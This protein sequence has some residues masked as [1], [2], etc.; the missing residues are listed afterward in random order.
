M[1]QISLLI[2]KKLQEVPQMRTLEDMSD[3]AEELSRKLVFLGLFL[4]SSSGKIMLAMDSMLT[5]FSSV[6]RLLSLKSSLRVYKQKVQKTRFQHL[7]LS[8]NENLELKMERSQHLF[9]I[10]LMRL[11]AELMHKLILHLMHCKLMGKNIVS[12]LIMEMLISHIGISFH[13][14]QFITGL[15]KI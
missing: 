13:L 9:R 3:L 5:R 14:T 8:S 6:K 11:V 7:Y 1:K 4:N 12:Q 2:S 10:P 15:C